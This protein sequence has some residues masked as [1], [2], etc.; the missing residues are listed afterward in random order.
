MLNHPRILTL[1][2]FFHPNMLQ[3]P[4]LIAVYL[5]LI[6]QFCINFQSPLLALILSQIVFYY[7]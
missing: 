7:F 3:K 4:V 5:L 2:P 6:L 1:D